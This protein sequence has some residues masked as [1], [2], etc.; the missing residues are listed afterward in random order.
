MEPSR[1]AV[2]EDWRWR[3]VLC[4]SAAL[5]AALGGSFFLGPTARADDLEPSPAWAAADSPP[6]ATAPVTADTPQT[7]DG[8]TDADEPSDTT[9]PAPAADTDPSSDA[10][11]PE[12]ATDPTDTGGTLVDDTGPG[13]DAAPT[14]DTPATTPA[15]PD[16]ADPA[17]PSDSSTATDAAPTT[18]T[19]ATT[20][21]PPDCADPAE[22]SDTSTATDT[23]PTTDAPGTSRDA[24][25]CTRAPDT[26]GAPADAGPAPAPGNSATQVS[27]SQELCAGRGRGRDAGDKKD[28]VPSAS[29]PALADGGSHAPGDPGTASGPGVGSTA[30]SLATSPAGQAARSG[31]T[32]LVSLLGRPHLHVFTASSGRGGRGGS[33][34]GTT[35]IKAT[36][37]PASHLAPDLDGV[38]RRQFDRRVVVCAVASSAGVRSDSDRVHLTQ[39]P[40]AVDTTQAG[41]SGLTTREQ[42]GNRN[43]SRQ[44]GWPVPPRHDDTPSM[45]PAPTSLQG[46]G[47][48]GGMH[49]YGVKG[50]VTARFSLIPPRDRRLLALVD[51]PRRALRLFFLLERPG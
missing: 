30:G 7:A 40:I 5:L 4:C 6:A 17:K 49:G 14:T 43:R 18:E 1:V 25:G 24:A 45:P 20:P 27:S 29:E 41:R 19:P 10:D 47:G 26:S 8:A 3:W 21:A 2:L 48:S 35:P 38:I 39:A 31:L 50:V 32:T 33:G 34:A 37:A 44:P 12:T 46:S 22:P 42:S 36:L 13:T 51:T 28:S 15:S 16:C 9:A 11:E 23:G